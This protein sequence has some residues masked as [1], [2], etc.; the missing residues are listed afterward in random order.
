MPL[1]DVAQADNSAILALD[2]G[3]VTLTAPG[4]GGAVYTLPGQF[5]RIGVDLN[6]EGLPIPAD[7]ATLTVSINALL[8]LGLAS[9]DTLKTTSGWTATI[10][11]T[12][13]RVDSTALDRSLGRATMLLKRT[14]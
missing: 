2:C 7:K 9:I 14:A 10:G 3:N 12:V 6:A 13:F 11:T 4:V 1:I 5:F 8:A